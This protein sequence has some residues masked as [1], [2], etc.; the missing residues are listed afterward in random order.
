MKFLI[1]AI[2]TVFII[3]FTKKGL[4]VEQK[5]RWSGE[6]KKRYFNPF[7]LLLPVVFVIYVVFAEYVFLLDNNLNSIN[8]AYSW[9]LVLLIS[10]SIIL[11]ETPK[12]EMI[13]KII[14]A[15]GLVILLVSTLVITMF[16]AEDKYRSVKVV[17][18][19]ISEV[20]TEEDTPFSVPMKTASK[21]MN[22][23]FGDLENVSYYGLGEITPQVVNGEPVYV[24]P[25]EIAGIF[26]A[27]KIDSVPGYI[28]MSGLNPN[29]DP[30]VHFDYKM[31]YVPSDYFSRN[32][33]RLTTKKYPNLIFYGDPKFEIND[34]G[35]PY[36][37]R[38]Y[39]SFVAG[40]TGFVAEGILLIDPETG[41][42]TKHTKKNKPE[43]IDGIVNSDTA[44]L[45]NKYYG[46]LPHGYINKAQTDVK[47]PT[48]SGT[49]NGV[50]PIIGKD[51]KM[52]FFTD[53]SSPK[54][55]V[56]SALGYSLIDSEEN[57]LYYYS[58]KQLKGLMDSTSA[59]ET[60]D[61]KF[62]K[63]G[64][65]G[66]MPVLYNVYDKASWIVPVID[67]AGLVQSFAIVAGSNGNVFATGST[68]KQAFKNYKN[69]LERDLQTIERASKKAVEAKAEVEVLR[70][71]KSESQD[72]TI[73]EVLAKD[74]IY[75]ISVNDFA[76]AKFIMPNDK[77]QITFMDNGEQE[78]AVTDYVNITLEQLKR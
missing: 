46:E 66:T 42:I 12:W 8:Y 30:V 39:G 33:E 6:V 54:D 59:K 28:T 67:D 62:K 43:F 22:K 29:A 37:T 36:Y 2:L 44:M 38:T 10:A 56:E 65:K 27:F 70:I 64:W 68:M 26:K 4:L 71:S 51:G 20:F 78:V 15:A 41:E 75:M 60:V 76:E 63:E 61:T 49:V 57:V 3:P 14:V 35:K 11:S 72:N 13:L 55:S 31:K 53:F 19:D 40:R 17:E 18:K 47:I 24:A 21:K 25:I 69:A 74:R 48:D 9:V 5:D 1:L 45:I 73:I 50:T 52:Y 32:L 23:Y 7:T 16:S 77:L 34:E 58:G